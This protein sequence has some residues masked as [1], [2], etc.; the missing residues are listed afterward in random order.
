[1]LVLS[2]T[3]PFVGCCIQDT[4]K[5]TPIPTVMSATTSSDG[6]GSEDYPDDSSSSSGMSSETYP[7]VFEF[8]DDVVKNIMTQ[9]ELDA[10]FDRMA[11]GHW[12]DDI[13]MGRSTDG[14]P[15]MPAIVLGNDPKNPIVIDDTD[16]ESVVETVPEGHTSGYPSFVFVAV[17]GSNF[18]DSPSS[19]I[20]INSVTGEALESA[21]QPQSILRI[22]ICLP[23]VRIRY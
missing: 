15:Q 5:S 6:F 8:S 19:V 23:K 7:C 11:D 17:H 18:R 14:T 21:R 4:N 3:D 16:E 2:G 22:W 10:E 13:S 1:M 9:A 12:L 20:K